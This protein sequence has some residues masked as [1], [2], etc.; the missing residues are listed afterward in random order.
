M[1]GIRQLIKIGGVNWSVITQETL[2]ILKLILVAEIVRLM[3]AEFLIVLQIIL[4]LLKSIVT[5]KLV[6][7][8][9]KRDKIIV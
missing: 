4:P 2:L 1:E 7:Y 8:F 3:I 9:I 6:V 5:G